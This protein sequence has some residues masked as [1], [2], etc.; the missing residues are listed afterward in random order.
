[1]KFQV[2]QEAD[3]EEWGVAAVDALDHEDAATEW[4]KKYDWESAEYDIV[5][6]RMTPVV[7]VR[8]QGEDLVMRFSVRGGAV[9]E[10]YADELHE[11][12]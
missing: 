12:A 7:C 9:P 10:Y 11:D 8:R 5:A 2:W 4:A 1:M 6:G 3:G